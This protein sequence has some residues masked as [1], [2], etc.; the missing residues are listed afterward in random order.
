MRITTSNANNK[1]KRKE[2]EKNIKHKEAMMIVH[3]TDLIVPSKVPLQSRQLD[4]L[5]KKE[6]AVN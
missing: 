3:R 1:K 2:E 6:G 4:G 5:L